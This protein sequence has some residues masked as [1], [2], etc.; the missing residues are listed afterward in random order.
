MPQAVDLRRQQDDHR[1]LVVAIGQFERLVAVGRDSV[2]SGLVPP[3]VVHV[4]E[5]DWITVAVL[6]EE[7][8]MHERG[9]H[10]GGAGQVERLGRGI[11]LLE[12]CG[13]DTQ[14]VDGIGENKSG[15]GIN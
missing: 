14:E 9:L 1:K 3:P 2:S 6:H 5:R 10:E 13:P 12:G 11:R 8:L 7:G 15:V 4:V